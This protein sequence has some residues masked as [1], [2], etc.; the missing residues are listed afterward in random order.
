MVRFTLSARSRRI[1]FHG[2]SNCSNVAVALHRPTG[3]FIASILVMR[4]C[5]LLQCHAYYVQ[6]LARVVPTPEFPSRWRDEYVGVGVGVAGFLF[7]MG[8][9]E[10]K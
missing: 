9:D 3:K 7:A 5:N 6:R 1:S 8:W 10:M 2:F 4:D